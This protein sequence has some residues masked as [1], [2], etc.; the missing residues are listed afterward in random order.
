MKQVGTVSL[1]S[2]SFRPELLLDS[3]DNICTN[4]EKLAKVLCHQLTNC[5]RF[6]LLS[7]S[8]PCLLGGIFFSISPYLRNLRKSS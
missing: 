7:L 2:E 6:P 3:G 8:S 4:E 1:Y 5:K